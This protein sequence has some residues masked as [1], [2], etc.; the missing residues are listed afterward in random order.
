MLTVHDTLPPSVYSV[1]S[2]VFTRAGSYLG[3]AAKPFRHAKPQD[4][5][6]WGTADIHL[7]TGRGGNA[8][9]GSNLCMQLRPMHHG[10]RVPFAVHGTPAELQLLTAYGDIRFCFAEPGLLLIRGEK[11]LSLCLE[12]DLGLHQIFRKRGGQSWESTHLPC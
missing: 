8:G 4:M 5:G 6:R 7:V 3:V 9:R 1:A 10:V 2:Q 12:A 11:G